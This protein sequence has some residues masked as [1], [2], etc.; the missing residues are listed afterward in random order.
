MEIT[1]PDNQNQLLVL[2]LNAPNADPITGSTHPRGSL[3]PDL[4]F[5]PDGQRILYIAGGVDNA[6]YALDLKSSTEQRIVRGNFAEGMALASD[7]T[8]V[9]LLNNAHV[10]DPKQ[11]TYVNLVLADLSSAAL[12]TLYPGA[13]VA[14]GKVSN[15]RFAYPLT[16][17]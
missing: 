4:A 17:R 14:N 3:I 12:T 15:L 8:T 16:W 7:G 9:A 10:D 5:T 11:P 2:D 6:L 13:D 1:S